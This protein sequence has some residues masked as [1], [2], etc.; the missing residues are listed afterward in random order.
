MA[1]AQQA[2]YCRRGKQWSPLRG[3]YRGLACADCGAV[4]D[5]MYVIL[6]GGRIVHAYCPAH[7]EQA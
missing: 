1:A 4:Q 2:V 5:V 3:I 7:Q 6:D